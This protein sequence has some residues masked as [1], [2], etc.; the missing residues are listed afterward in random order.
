MDMSSSG[1]GPTAP[2]ELTAAALQGG[3]HLTWKD[4]SDNEE[5]FML[6]RKQM[7]VDSDYKVI[8]TLPFDSVQYHDAPLVSGATYSYKVMAMNGKGESESNE[9][10]FKAP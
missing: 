9:V 6:E 10:T 7:G 4:N 1:A 2:S 8:A 3:A 5:S